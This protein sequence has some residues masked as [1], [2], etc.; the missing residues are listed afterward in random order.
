MVLTSLSSDKKSS[1]NYE[2]YYNVPISLSDD[3]YEIALIGC[4][5]CFFLV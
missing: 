5:I 3:N 4:N 2:V 1:E